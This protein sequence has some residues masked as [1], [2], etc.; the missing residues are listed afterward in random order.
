MAKN[1]VSIPT[2]VQSPFIVVTIGGVTFGTYTG[3]TYQTNV[4]YPNFMKSMSV[5]KVNGT[6]NTYTL[7][8]QYQVRTGDDPNLLDKIFSKATVDRQITF[9]YGDWNAPAYIYKEEKAIITNVT[10]SLDMNNSMINYTVSATSDA[11]G[12]SSTL[13]S[14]PARE[15]KPSDVFLNLVSN[16]RYGLKKVFTGMRNTSNILQ[17]SLIASNDKKVKL[18]AQKD[19]SVLE[20]MNYLTD[21]MISTSNKEGSV[22]QNSKYYLTIHDDFTNDVGGT[23]FQVSEVSKN[24]QTIKSTDTYEIDVN[25][26]GDNFVTQFSLTNDQSWAILYEFNEAVKQEQYSYKI[27]DDGS[28]ETSYTPSMMKSD[29]TD[30]LSPSKSSWWSRM[31]EF[32]IEATLTIKGLTRPSMLMT[33]VKLN[34]LFAGGVK[35]ISSGTYIITKQVDNIDSNGY[36]T[37]LTLLRIAGDSPSYQEP[38]LRA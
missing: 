1:L 9:Q 30:A 8:F 2:L 28:I 13:Y 17:N 36:T 38:L 15:A 23:Y 37:T 35:H 6:V 22:I 34:V 32:P 4:T 16:S 21:S 33:Y 24:T 10:S 19:V 20:Y 5:V 14:F 26:P 25:Y 31:T 12:L 3:D 7:N 11:I 18:L 27:R 29:T